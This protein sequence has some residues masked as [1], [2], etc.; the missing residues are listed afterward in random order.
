MFIL[1]IAA[2]A[3]SVFAILVGMIAILG[4]RSPTTKV[5]TVAATTAPATSPATPARTTTPPPSTGHNIPWKKVVKIMTRLTLAFLLIGGLLWVAPQVLKFFGGQDWDW[6]WDL[7]WP[8]SWPTPSDILLDPVVWFIVGIVLL[9]IVTSQTGLI[10]AIAGILLLILIF[11]F[12]LNGCT[13]RTLEW[14]DRGLNH[15]DWSEQADYYRTVS[16]GTVWMRR[17]V[18]E[19]FYVVGE[20][21]L[22]NNNDFTLLRIS[23]G[24]R[25]HIR[26]QD[27]SRVVFIRAKSGKKEL[28]LVEVVD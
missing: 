11:G 14:F 9:G 21:R 15:G 4:N 8:S 12:G 10:R 17:G 28:V 2:I 13:E 22:I 5:L 25:F 3:A 1:G 7:N 18:P 6:T 19:K 16:N 23:P 27:E 26:E 24:G 20:V